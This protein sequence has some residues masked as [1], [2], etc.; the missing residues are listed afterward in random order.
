MGPLIDGVAWKRVDAL[1]SSAI[2]QGAKLLFGGGRPVG[3]NTGHYH[4]PTVL[5]GVDSDIRIYREEIFGPVVSLIEFDDEEEV[6]KAA[7]DTE[8]GLTAYA[9]IRDLEKVQRCVRRLRFG[10]VQV[11]GIKY[12]IDLPHGGI[13]QSGIGCDCS[14]LALHDYLAPKRISQ[15]LAG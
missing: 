9:F 11:N 4:S 2:D 14:H 15:A 8:A 6:L 13:K 3:F 7:N 12:A 10:E 1:A 5:D